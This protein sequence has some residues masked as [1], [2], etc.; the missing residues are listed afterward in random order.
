MVLDENGLLYVSLIGA[1]QVLVYDTHKLREIERITL[2]D[3]ASAPYDVMYDPARKALWMGTVNNDSL[4][5]YDLA[6][7]RFSEYPLGIAHLNLRIVAI[8]DKSGDLWI[9]NSPIP[10]NEPDMRRVFMVHPGD[11]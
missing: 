11:R 2:P 3:A 8:D 9:A 5:R 1:G 4:F 6:T 10:S 7:R